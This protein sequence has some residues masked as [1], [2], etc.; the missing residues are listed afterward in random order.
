LFNYFYLFILEILAPSVNNDCNLQNEIL[1]ENYPSPC[2]PSSTH[3]QII[4]GESQNCAHSD[5][6]FVVSMS[7]GFLVLEPADLSVPRESVQVLFN[8]QMFS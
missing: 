5:Q 6:F 8:R 2:S 7:K 1:E 4:S 3:P